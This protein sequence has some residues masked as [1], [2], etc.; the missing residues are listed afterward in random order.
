MENVLLAETK[1]DSKNRDEFLQ[2]SEFIE[3]YENGV[4]DACKIDIQLQKLEKLA[5]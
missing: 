5:S 2:T 3:N 1:I 4:I